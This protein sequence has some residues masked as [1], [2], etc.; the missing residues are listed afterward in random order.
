MKTKPLT[1]W[2][3]R[4]RGE[5]GP[6][7]VIYLWFDRPRLA[8]P[9]AKAYTW[10]PNA[11]SECESESPVLPVALFK[12]WVGKVPRCDRP[13]QLRLTAVPLALRKKKKK[14]TPAQRRANKFYH[15]WT[16]EGVK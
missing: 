9:H 12:A 15:P 4:N 11:D 14:K 1:I 3:T 8:D 5:D 16:N 6:R 2:A 7:P 13:L 10:W